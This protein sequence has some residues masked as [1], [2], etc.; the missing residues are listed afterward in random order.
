MAK[1]KHIDA[2]VFAGKVY[3]NHGVLCVPSYLGNQADAETV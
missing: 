3:P 1:E 2:D